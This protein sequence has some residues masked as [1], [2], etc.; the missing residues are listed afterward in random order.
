MTTAGS[1]WRTAVA[2][3]LLVLGCLAAAGAVPAMWAKQQLTSGRYLTTVRPL[4]KEPAVQDAVAVRVTTELRTALNI[5]GMVDRG[6]AA[7][8]LA[9][10]PRSVLDD[11]RGVLQPADAAV[12]ALAEKEIRTALDTPAAEQ[13]WLDANR[14]ARDAIV[15]GDRTEVVVD[16]TPL[17][18]QVRRQLVAEGLTV[19][20]QVKVGNPKLVLVRG[21]SLEQARVR[22][23]QLASLAMVLPVVAGGL[24]VLAFLVSRRRRRLL[25]LAGIGVSLAMVGLLAAPELLR[26]RAQRSFGTEQPSRAIATELYDAL[27][28]SLRTTT[29]WVLAGAVVFTLVMTLILS[30]RARSAA[31]LDRRGESRMESAAEPPPGSAAD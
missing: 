26:D 14:S 21:E 8:Q 25:Q 5:Q 7:A 18:E 6:L 13:V 20:R 12:T 24:L 11:L 28:G 19:A 15:R 31:R 3:I 23:E 22:Y 27:A 10:I 4:V 17:V 16:L 29:L 2:G 1:S 30:E 9:G